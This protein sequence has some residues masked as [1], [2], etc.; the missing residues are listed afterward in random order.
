MSATPHVADFAERA[1]PALANRRRPGWRPRLLKSGS[2]VL[3]PGGGGR[4]VFLD[5]RSRP[6]NAH[7]EDIHPYNADA[8]RLALEAIST[9]VNVKGTAADM[10]LRRAEVPEELINRFLIERDPATGKKRTKREAGAI[11]LDTLTASGGVGQI[12]ARIIA[13][14][15]DWTAFHLAAN[16]YEARAIVEKA[17]GVRGALEAVQARARAAESEAREAEARLRR[18]ERRKLVATESALLLQMFDDQVSGQGS[19]QQRGYFLEDLLARAFAL[20]DIPVCRS[21][22]RNDQAEQIDAAFELDG[23]YYIVE[24]RWRQG[25]ADMRELDG[26]AGQVRR[27]GRQTMGMFLAINGWSTNVVPLLKQEPDKSIFLMEGSDLRAVL[28][29]SVDFKLLL[30][31]KIRALNLQS[32]PYVSASSVV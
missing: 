2:G 29:Q 18:S 22:R 26:L 6:L 25:Q 13:I 19:A 17:K 32:E 10:L 9:L 7:T 31:A 23:C 21:F 27:S 30:K 24:C 20:H 8:Y 4:L 28:A 15:A 11:L 12:V 3:I 5:E 16:E 1:G 14:A